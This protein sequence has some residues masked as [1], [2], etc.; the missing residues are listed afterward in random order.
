MPRL[1]IYS[2]CQCFGIAAALRRSA[3]AAA[4]LHMSCYENYMLMSA[5][6]GLPDAFRR[7]LELADIVLFQPLDA[8]H[9]LYAT[10]GGES[11]FAGLAP[12]PRQLVSFPYVF[13]GGLWPMYQYGRS[14]AGHELVARWKSRESA[15]R[16]EQRYHQLDL[17]FNL[18][19][20]FHASNEILREREKHCDLKAADF[21]TTGYRDARLFLTQNHPTGRVFAH[22]VEQ[23]A[24]LTGIALNR[25]ALAVVAEDLNPGNLP[26]FYPVGYFSRT[27]LGLRFDFQE[28]DKR[29][30]GHYLDLLRQSL[31]A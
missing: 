13:N 29:A 6:A 23:F 31:A 12:G 4:D 11:I 1:V 2:N 18:E 9:G 8:G 17:E 3:R 24:A 16:I 30:H 27:E 14:L 5:G 10:E 25:K 19:E 28:E 21:I 20:R 7:D 15:Q 22:L 26:G